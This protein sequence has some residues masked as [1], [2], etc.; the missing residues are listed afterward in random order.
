VNLGGDDLAAGVFVGKFTSS[1]EHLWSTSCQSDDQAYPW[2]YGAVDPSSGDVIIAGY[3]GQ[4]A[5]GS[6]TCGNIPLTG[7]DDVFVARLA[8]LDGSAIF[9][10]KFGGAGQDYLW[11]VAVDG[12]G[13][14][15]L[16][17][18]SLGGGI[19]FGGPSLTDGY[20]V[21]LASN[22]SHVWS[23][24]IGAGYPRALALDFAGGLAV[25]GGGQS[26]GIMNFGGEDLAAIGQSDLFVARWD[27]S[28]NYMWSRRFGSPG[29]NG[30]GGTDV[31]ID[32]QGN[33]AVTG[34]VWGNVPIDGVILTGDSNAFVTKF[35]AFGK[36]AWSRT[37]GA[38]EAYSVTF[39]SLN[40][41][42]VGG[43]SIVAVD[44]GEGLVN[45]VGESDLFLL[46]IAP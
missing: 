41:L 26:S 30:S 12:Q 3:F 36:A 42:V 23:K 25:I 22:G 13:S 9:S 15:F 29:A 5:M 1:G 33:L 44:F 27:E 32:S 21:K 28:G 4:F 35:D 37:F 20:V 10:K 14:I 2:P 18:R 31:T 8:A 17:G 24:A 11:S 34:L 19:S 39:S 46:K 43:Q 40:E 7:A 45:P 16:A 6:I 38:D